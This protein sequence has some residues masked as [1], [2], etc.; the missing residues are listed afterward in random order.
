M[1]DKKK[2]TLRL[3]TDN[4]EDVAKR[5][6]RSTKWPLACQTCGGDGDVPLTEADLD[7]EDENDT[8]AYC[9]DCL[10]KGQCPRCASKLPENWKEQ[11]KSV[12][13]GDELTCNRCHWEDGDDKVL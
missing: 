13:E 7:E 3:V 12:D 11:L 9:Q 2:P 1:P 4:P 6:K 10:G 8:V 5:V